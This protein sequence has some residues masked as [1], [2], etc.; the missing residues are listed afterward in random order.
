M[1][2]WVI[3]YDIRSPKRLQKVHKAMTRFAAPIEYSI[4]L[5]KGSDENLQH[6]LEKVSRLL[7]NAI[8]WI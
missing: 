4:F 5:Y 1:P 6:R 2:T 3:G 8:I 7:K